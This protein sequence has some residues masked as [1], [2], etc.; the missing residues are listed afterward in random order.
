MS[1]SLRLYAYEE[2]SPEQH[3]AAERRFRRAMDAALGDESLV[4]PVY[5]AYR[6][7]VSIYGEAPAEDTL[8]AEETEVFTQWQA[9]EAA[10]LTAA[11]G[12]DRYMGEAQFEIGEAD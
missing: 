1:Y 5:R 2:A 12:P 6:R 10:A 8:S 11:L 3:R 7:L 9:A 4:L